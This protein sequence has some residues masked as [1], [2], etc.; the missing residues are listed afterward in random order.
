MVSAIQNAEK[1]TVLAPTNDAFNKILE[2][3]G[4]LEADVIKDIL[5]SHVIDGAVFSKDLVD[6]M[7]IQTLGSLTFEVKIKDGQ[8]FFMAEGAD[9]LVITADIEA[10]NGVVHV[11]DSVLIPQLAFEEVYLNL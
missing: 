11:I 3:L 7:T 1:L 9:G 2:V 10:S 4:T 5:L 6:G 8:V